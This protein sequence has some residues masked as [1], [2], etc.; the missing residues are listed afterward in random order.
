MH[1]LEFAEFFGFFPFRRRWGAKLRPHFSFR[2]SGVVWHVDSSRGKA[3]EVNI[4]T[5]AHTDHYGQRNVSNP[6][7]VASDET[8]RILEVCCG[9]FRGK[10]FE[11][12]EKLRIKTR[13]GLVKVRTYP[14]HHMHGSSAF[15]FGDILITGDVK[16]YSDLPKC[17]V[18]VTE[19]TYGSPEFTFED[20]VD[21]LVKVGN[22][23]LGAYPIGKS[24]R[25]AKILLD[26]GYEVCVEGKAGRICRALGIDVS[27]RGDVTLTSLRELGKYYGRKFVL[28]AQ[29]FY[30]FPRIVLSDHLDYNGIIEMVE[31][32]NPECVIFYHGSPSDEL[33]NEVK[34]LGCDV[35]LLDDLVVV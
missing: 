11:V 35:T 6:H 7:A 28:T 1:S 31:H 15:M 20:E 9:E 13:E 33:I 34:G 24:Q 32:C 23:V 18:L 2:Y 30:R 5:H 16:N 8:A 12:G 26:A 29:R 19:A 22:A 27:D 14:T 25:A 4:I 10:I 17:K 3:G 21:K